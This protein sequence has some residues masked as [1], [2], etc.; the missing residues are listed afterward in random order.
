MT[1]ADGRSRNPLARPPHGVTRLMFRTSI[2]L[3]PFRLGW[4]LGRGFLLLVHTGR[5][6]AKER[7]NVLEVMGSDPVAGESFVMTG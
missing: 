6:T 5:K 3:Y 7:R 2:L 1:K 4:L